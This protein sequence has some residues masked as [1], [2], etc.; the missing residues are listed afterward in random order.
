MDSAQHE[1]AC[2][3]V[4]AGGLI[5]RKASASNQVMIVHRKRYGDWT[6]PK[7]KLKEGE[8]YQAAALREVKEETGCL[9]QLGEYAGALGYQANGVPKVVLFWRMSV[10]EQ[11][12]IQDLEESKEVEWLSIPAAIERLTYDQE[13]TFLERLEGS[14]ARSSRKRHWFYG[15]L[16]RERLSRELAVFTVELQ[17][18]ERRSGSSDTSWVVAARQHLLNADRYLKRG[19]TESGWVCLHAAQRYGL[20]GLTPP[21]LANRASSLRHETKKISGW[22][23]DAMKDLVKEDEITRARIFD[24]MAIRDE[25]SSNQYYKIWLT[26]DQLLKVLIPVCVLAFLSLIVLTLLSPHTFFQY[27]SNEAWKFQ[28]ILAVL[29]FGLLGASFSV[30]QSLMSNPGTAR[31]PERVENHYVTLTRLLSGAIVGLASYAFF[32][33]KAFTIKG[34]EE[35]AGA[36]FTIAFLFGYMGEKLVARVAGSASAEKPKS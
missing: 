4:A 19:A 36:A 9:C 27:T 30:A 22:R 10:I 7:G 2:V 31:I 20:F 26:K 25:H 24:A 23:S 34:L 18:L 3:V 15:K 12:A 32:V 11:G 21:E 5:V 6:L 35:S 8:S 17:F 14:A 1:N 33:S 13:K 29:D 28:T 16:E